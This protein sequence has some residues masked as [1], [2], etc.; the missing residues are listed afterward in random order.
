MTSSQ[1]RK[2]QKQRLLLVGSQ[3]GF[4]GAGVVRVFGED[5]FQLVARSSTLV[6]ALA[7]LAPGTLDVVVI[8][9]EFSSHELELF[10]AEARRRKFDGLILHPLEALEL[11]PEMEPPAGRLIRAG[12]L[13]VDASVQQVWIRGDKVR[14][15]SLEYRLLRFFSEHPGESMS[16][17]SLM[18]VIW[19]DPI[20]RRHSLRELIRSV[21][22]KIE[23]ASPPRY[24][25]TQRQFG[26][27]FVPSPGGD[28]EWITSDACT[29]TPHG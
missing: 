19:G 23:N 15:N 1:T 29:P 17:R 10:A 5:K 25:V 3:V 11:P 16:Y 13:V 26:Y 28:H 22:A 7:C 4:K 9:N 12:D 18:E 21:R 8:S 27:R 6:E 24:I 2:R 20:G 14:L